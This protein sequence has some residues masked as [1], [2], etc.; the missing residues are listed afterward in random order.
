MDQNP[1]EAGSSTTNYQKPEEGVL[2]T[3]GEPSKGTSLIQLVQK[4]VH[5]FHK[6]VCSG[7]S[8]LSGAFIKSSK[9]AGKILSLRRVPSD[10]V[11][12]KED[13]PE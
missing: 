12:N 11:T 5:T 4:G 3:D 10:V 8:W 7:W 9:E 2:A 1:E 6:T 13:Q